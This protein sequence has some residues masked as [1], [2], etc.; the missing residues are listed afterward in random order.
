MS[1][2]SDVTPRPRQAR[3]WRRASGGH[4]LPDVFHAYDRENRAACQPAVR[5]D[6][7]SEPPHEGSDL[8][9]ECDS[10]VRTEVPR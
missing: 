3:E 9:A 5:L 1:D 6:E 10:V 4:W 2:G 8:C 7:S